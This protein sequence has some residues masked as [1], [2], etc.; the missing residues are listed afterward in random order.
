MADTKIS[1]MTPSSTPLDGTELVPL[2]QGG[3]NV[4]GTVAEIWQQSL[5][6]STQY[7]EVYDR[8]ASIAL[9]GTPTLLKPVSTGSNSGITYSSSTGVFTFPDEGNFA[10]SINLN[11]TPS[12]SN[13]YVYV[14]AEQ[15]VGSGWAL[16]ANSGKAYL[17]TNSGQTVQIVYSQA[18]HRVAGQQVR[19][20]IYSNDGKVALE[21]VTLPGTSTAYV[22]A[23][24]IQYA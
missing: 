20:Y 6:T 21:T 4:K 7:I 10:L 19:Y 17:L 23:I 15:N 14:Y 13:Q 11:A 5:A 18:V 2:V 22:P 24:R 12:A 8:S 9:T 1:A 16:N 3:N